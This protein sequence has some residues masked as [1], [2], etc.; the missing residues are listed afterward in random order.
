MET[1]A[2]LETRRERL[3]A[4]MRA[5]RSM[6]RAT[7]NEQFLK[8]PHKGKA[9]PIL[10]GP[11]YVMSWHEKGKTIGRRL[12]ADAELKQARKDIEAHKRFMALCQEFV[13]VTERLG[14]L[15]RRTL[16]EKG[17]EKKRRKSPSSR[18]RR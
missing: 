9:E 18:M 8:V 5:I 6:K 13:Q 1:L 4:D 7:I 3:L 16:E 11:Y 15:E 12:T 17:A 2:D 10:R 14:E